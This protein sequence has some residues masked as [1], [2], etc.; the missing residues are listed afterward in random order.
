MVR[1]VARPAKI[2][3]AL[4]KCGVTLLVLFT[5]VENVNGVAVS[6]AFGFLCCDRPLKSVL[7]VAYC[8]VSS[9]IF[10]FLA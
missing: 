10:R 6:N 1:C 4:Q 8:V 7:Q 5:K 3:Q 9:S 2:S